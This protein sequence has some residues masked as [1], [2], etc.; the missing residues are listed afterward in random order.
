MSIENSI[1]EVVK[2]LVEKAV[3]ARF[4]KLSS[5]NYSLQTRLDWTEK[6]LNETL[7]K[8]STRN[9][10]L[11]DNE[12]S[13]DKIDGGTI[14]TFASTGIKDDASDKKLTI[15]DDKITVENDIHIK[16]QIYCDTLH[17]STANATNLD[18]SNSIRIG[19]NEVLWRD[20][21]GN[22]VKSSKLTEVGVLKQ[23]NVADIFTVEGGR[24]G[25]NVETPGGVLGI[26]KDGLEI[27]FDVVGS[28]PFIGT[29]T[30]DK[31]AIGTNREPTLI[32]SHDNKIGIKVKAPK[33]DLE[34][35]GAIRYQGQTHSYANS[36]PT[37]GN[38]EQGDIVWNARPEPGKTF[39]WVCVKSG[40]PG[41][42]CEIGNV[43]PI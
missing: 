19:G 8:L 37:N 35:A 33:E 26:A 13:G 40:A 11:F 17:Y 34:V 20:R 7:E 14:T 16:G 32:V 10:D 12:V 23:I 31:F 25:I 2:E 1:N 43:S 6:K 38:H 30:S 9:N 42:W 5:D 27:V 3:K 24:V 22:S 28:T 4:D 21:L 18:L 29:N 41:T 15:T 36:M 39:G